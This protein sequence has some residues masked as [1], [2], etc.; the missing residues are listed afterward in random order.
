MSELICLLKMMVF[1]NSNNTRHVCVDRWI[2]TVHSCVVYFML[3]KVRKDV[4][5]QANKHVTSRLGRLHSMTLLC[6][7]V[8]SHLYSLLH[9]GPHGS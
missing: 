1:T 7:S 9:V 3:C 5:M 4:R 2:H 8:P 6:E